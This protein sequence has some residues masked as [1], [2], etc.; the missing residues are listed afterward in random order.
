M[1]QGSEG[2][3]YREDTV[4]TSTNV[5]NAGAGSETRN[6]DGEGTCDGSSLVSDDERRG[7]AVKGGDGE[8]GGEEGI[9]VELEF[10]RTS[11][12]VRLGNETNVRISVDL[13]SVND[14]V[15]RNEG[16]G[17]SVWDDSNIDRVG[18]F[19]DNGTAE[20]KGGDLHVAETKRELLDASKLDEFDI[21]SVLG[22]GDVNLNA[23]LEADGGRGRHKLFEG[24]EEEEMLEMKRG[25][26]AHK[27]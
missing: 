9:K 14:G 2:S 12:G 6:G 19:R 1:E 22:G 10:K 26:K 27:E 3:S 23:G 24:G 21:V 11:C 7:E 15:G 8:I 17:P 25:G 18:R 5:G 20:G 4:T 16:G 13:E